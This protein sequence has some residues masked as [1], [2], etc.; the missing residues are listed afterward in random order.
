[1]GPVFDAGRIAQPSTHVFCIGVG[2]YRHLPGGGGPVAAK[3]LGLKQLASP[4][5]SAKAVAE[6]FMTGPAGQPGMFFNPAAPLGTVRCL[7][8]APAPV[9]VQTPQGDVQ[10]DAAI[11]ANI[12]AEFAGWLNDVKSNPGN[13]GVFYFCGHGLMVSDH[14]LLAEDYGSGLQPWLNAFDISST[15]R[16]VERE[17]KGALFF[18]ID[19]CREVSRE[20]SLS[21]GANPQA[22]M[23]ADLTR[24]VLR[25]SLTRISATG[26]GELAFAPPG[27][28]VSRFTSAMLRALSGYAGLKMAG[29]AFWDIDG[30]ALASAT[31]RLLENE[32]PPPGGTAQYSEQ[33]IHGRSVPL[34]R[35]STPPKVAISINYLPVNRRSSYELYARSIGMHVKQTREDRVLEAVVPMGIYA[36]GAS[37]PDGALPPD[38]RAE[39]DIRPPIYEILLGGTP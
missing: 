2:R 17:A 4:P 11:K 36:V 20:L 5:V 12:D 31:R 32:F 34:V 22:L 38:E 27:G 24:P 29:Q 18:F 25:S 7:L 6:W 1:M 13:V 19:A 37:D 35:L 39:E 28:K 26:E 10:A 15:M 3:P 14:Y 30:E 8:S 9:L 16:A 23:P 33:S 21:A